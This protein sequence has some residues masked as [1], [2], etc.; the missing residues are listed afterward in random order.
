M[1]KSNSVVTWGQAELLLEASAEGA[2]AL[3]YKWL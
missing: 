1:V 2:R 3:K